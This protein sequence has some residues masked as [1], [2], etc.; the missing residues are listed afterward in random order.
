MAIL[1]RAKAE[2]P[3]WFRVV[4]ETN[5]S[6]AAVTTKTQQ[7]QEANRLKR[8]RSSEALIP[9]AKTSKTE[10]RPLSRHQSD[11]AID[12]QSLGTPILIQ[13]CPEYLEQHE[14][15]Q[16]LAMQM[17]D[18][19]NVIHNIYFL[20]A[21]K[22]PSE[23]CK[24]VSLDTMLIEPHNPVEGDEGHLFWQVRVARL[25]AE[26]ALRFDCPAARCRWHR[27]DIM[28]YS[29][30]T[31]D[32]LP[33]PFLKVEIEDEI[34]DQLTSRN[35]T[36]LNVAFMLLEIGL[37]KP[38][39]IPKNWDNERKRSRIL[40]LAAENDV[41]IPGNYFAVVRSCAELSAMEEAADVDEE[42]FREQ[43]YERIISPLKAMEDNLWSIRRKMN[44][45][46]LGA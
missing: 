35:T 2:K 40:E 44:K 9:P 36:L 45:L 21:K 15:P 8:R 42:R 22:R 11:T 33:E 34:S 14:E 27:G 30:Q 3:I 10:A 31:S 26:A 5:V 37:S 19:P 41:Q 29:L 23:E 4:S 32:D 12:T 46:T 1:S 18:S 7:E 16:F 24:P 25:I 6:S 13:I 43:Y 28:F 39:D 20:P 38:I 17:N